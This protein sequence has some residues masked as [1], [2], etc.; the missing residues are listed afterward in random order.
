MPPNLVLIGM[1]CAGKTSMGKVIAKKLRLDFIDT[2]DLIEDMHNSSLLDIHSRGDEEFLEAEKRTILS[3]K[4]SSSLI[5]TGGSVVLSP[6]VMDH[7]RDDLIV[8]IDVPPGIIQAR[9]GKRA[10]VG[11]VNN[12]ITG[13]YFS[14]HDLYK[15]YADKIVDAE[16]KSKEEIIRE[17]VSIYQH[18]A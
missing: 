17:I 8:F 11:M 7:F 4:P 1:P 10:V 5:A 18:V 3:F 9:M 13:V 15:R 14:R 2:D 12:N 6:E 16:G